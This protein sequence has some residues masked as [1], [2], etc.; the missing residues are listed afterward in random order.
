MDPRPFL[1]RELLGTVS[2][3]SSPSSLSKPS[4][5]SDVLDDSVVV[6]VVVEETDFDV[7]VDFDA[8]VV[9]VVVVVG[10]GDDFDS[11]SM[12]LTASV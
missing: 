7:E 10:I 1:S 9:T 11:V 8:V 2:Q 3:I 6:V 5:E 4:G 12:L